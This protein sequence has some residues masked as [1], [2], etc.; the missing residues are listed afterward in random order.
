VIKIYETGFTTLI[1]N[2]GVIVSH[3]DEK[4]I[5]KNFFD[6]QS[7]KKEEI[8]N[9]IQKGFE[10]QTETI[11]EF[12]GERVFRF[13][14]P[15]HI[16]G[17]KN[18]WSVM[19]EIPV[20]E[21]TSRS[22]QLTYA[23]IGTLLLGLLLLV[24][25]IQTI[26]KQRKYEK[27]LFESLI[28]EEENRRRIAESEHNYRILFENAQIG[29]FRTTPE[30]KFINAN[31]TL[32]NILGYEHYEEIRELNMQDIGYYDDITRAE[33]IKEI[34]EKGRITNFEARWV[35]RKGE[36]IYLLENAIAIKDINEKT[37]YYDGFVE[38]ITK[39]KNAENELK[40]SEA[41]YRSIIESFPDFLIVSDSESY[42]FYMNDIAQKMTGITPDLYKKTKWRDII[43]GRWNDI[44][45]KEFENLLNEEK[46]YSS[47]IDFQ[48]IDIFEQEHWFSGI[49]SK[50]KVNNVLLVQFIS[51]DITEKKKAEDELNEHKENLEVLV[52]SRTEELSAI[53]EE[54]KSSNDELLYRRE[55]LE[56]AL[57]DLK[58][59]Q[60]QLIQ[61]E[62]MASLGIL[63]AGIA[64][65]INNPLNFIS[66]GIFGLE[67]VL[68]TKTH[69]IFN[70][71]KPFI[72]SI[73]EG[74]KRATKIV[75]GLSRYSRKD[76]QNLMSCDIKMIIDNC[77]MMLNFNL[78]EKIKVIKNYEEENY[79]VHG[80]EGRLH[81]AFLNII[82]N[83]EQAIN[84]YGEIIINIYKQKSE[85]VV[86]IIDSGIG[87]EEKEI[88]KIT[89][90]FYT[91]KAPGK[92]TGLGLSITYQIIKEHHGKLE[93]NST[94]KIG[95]RVKVILPKLP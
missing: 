70:E 10:F 19:V 41:R 65:E 34:E 71:A 36:I 54:L 69:E 23:A 80:N 31:P 17:L 86:E 94:P 16:E 76:D 27:Q 61:S 43:R 68:K 48:Y 72:S 89:D 25:L 38:D 58:K 35:N 33:F 88:L 44:L 50:I 84:E 28:K 39:R 15:V 64:H 24:Y 18:P 40:E 60:Q 8:R 79:F 14:Y 82:S 53:N 32:L 92:G 21:V 81:Q 20:K 83:S 42:I 26:L 29:I 37:L 87:I 49:F 3:P 5:N 66:G 63:A 78:K 91:T 56:K 12:T 13:F 9:K 59:A 62:K 57:D 67:K 46:S 47:I 74:V 1:S 85:I 95:T 7:D 55:M 73:E 90:P 75:K 45:V 51:R 4:Y 30:G 52:K 11:S 77:L 22:S 93:I 6:Q 2:L